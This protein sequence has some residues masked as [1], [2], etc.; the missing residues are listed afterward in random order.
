MEFFYNKDAK[1]ARN[2]FEFGLKSYSHEPAFVMQCMLFSTAIIIFDVFLPQLF[3]S[4]VSLVFSFYDTNSTL[5]VVFLLLSFFGFV[6]VVFSLVFLLLFLSH[7]VDAEFL[8][9]LNEETN[10]RVLF[11]K[12]LTS[13][14]PDSAKTV[15]VRMRVFLCACAHAFKFVCVCAMAISCACTCVDVRVLVLACMCFCKCVRAPCY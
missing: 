9:H 8:T 12:A 14:P 3:L 4:F 6:I 7:D 5:F 15:R 13:I 10:M 11:E 2:L 1:V